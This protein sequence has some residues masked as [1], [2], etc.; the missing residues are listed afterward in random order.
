MF[1]G[2]V[3]GL[4][5]QGI[6]VDIAR[7]DEGL[8]TFALM[9]GAA[10]RYEID[11]PPWGQDPV[12]LA[13]SRII[14]QA[15]WFQPDAVIAVTG[16]KLHPSVPLT[17]RRLGIPTALLCTESP[18]SEEERQIAPMYDTV[19]TN[20]RVAVPL[21]TH[22]NVHYLPHA[23]NPA[24]HHAGSIDPAKQVDA[25]FIGTSFPERR[26]LFLGLDGVQL[27]GAAWHLPLEKQMD[28]ADNPWEGI[29]PN[30]E[31]AAWYRAA[32]VSLNHHRTSMGWN[33][34]RHISQAESLGPRAYEIPACGGFMLCDDSRPELFD[35][36]GDG[37]AAYRAGDRAD[38]ERQLDYWLAHPDRREESARMQ[39]AAVQPHSWHA[40]AAQ[41]AEVVLNQKARRRAA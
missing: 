34:G 14:T 13:A 12:A 41:V 40:R 11:L 28:D 32:R 2:L 4:R 10:T 20:E 17:L 33:D 3:A 27:L 6:T 18:Y 23:Y 9:T 35:V 25:V 1:S 26:D 30:H 24:V 22:T 29:T 36:F 37:V 19:F 38:L 15:A 31:A 5:A 21:F 16:L 8:E 39:H 7:L